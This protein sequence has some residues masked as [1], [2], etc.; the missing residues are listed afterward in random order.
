LRVRAV[1]S[2]PS[3][4]R[5]GGACSAY[6]VRTPRTAVLLDAGS[7]AIG[8]LQQAIE[9]TALDAIV[10]THMHAD[11]FLD[12]VPLR[13]GLTYGPSRRSSRLA[14]WL[15]PGGS[16]RLNA[17]AATFDSEGGDFF[18]DVIDV[19]EYDPQR[20]LRIGAMSLTFARALHYIESFSIR[21]ECSGTSF[22]YSGDTA[23]CDTVVEHARDAALFLCEATLGLGC[24]DPPRGHSSARE[25]GE[26]A[27][28]ASAG[29]LALTHYY[30]GVDPAALVAA[31]RAEFAGETTAVDDGMEFTL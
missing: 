14:V 19:A 24:E 4:Q 29:R 26:M 17:L 10:V 28:R 3:V 31:A 1:G 18:G 25:A 2:S 6:L 27:R 12:L 7:G 22:V 15:P 21:V 30:A 5:P 9:Y 20:A 16:K 8:K 13:Y 23:P 11:H